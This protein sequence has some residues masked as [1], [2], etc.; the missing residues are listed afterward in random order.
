M[1]SKKFLVFIVFFI[2]VSKNVFADNITPINHLNISRYN[3]LSPAM[4]DELVIDNLTIVFS[5]NKKWV[6]NLFNI[7][8]E[9]EIKKNESEHKNWFSNF[10][11]NKKFKKKFKANILVKFKDY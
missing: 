4:A 3:E 2:I 7:H 6:K 1:H 5:K 11:I 8:K 10:R 9:L